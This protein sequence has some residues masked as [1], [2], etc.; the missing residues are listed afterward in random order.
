MAAKT[1]RNTNST[2]TRP[3]A[4]CTNFKS[5]ILAALTHD[6][7]ARG[8]SATSFMTAF[9]AAGVRETKPE[10]TRNAPFE[11]DLDLKLIAHKDEFAAQSP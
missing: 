7:A 4:K 5:L 6:R 3:A 10:A 8:L 11:A 1:S 9:L 2:P